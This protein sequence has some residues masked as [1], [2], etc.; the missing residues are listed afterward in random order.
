MLASHF[1]PFVEGTPL[2]AMSRV[3]LENLFDPKRLDDLFVPIQIAVAL[4]AE[5]AA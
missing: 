2:C 3:V 1:T 4:V 5:L